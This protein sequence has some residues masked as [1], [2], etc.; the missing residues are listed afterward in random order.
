MIL[1]GLFPDTERVALLWL[2]QQFAKADGVTVYR[3]LPE[4]SWVAPVILIER[5]PGAN[6]AAEYE[7]QTD[8]DVTVFA[9]NRAALWA[10]VQKTEI[11]MR[12]LTGSAVARIDEVEQT[13]SFGL[14]PYS[15]PKVRRAIGGYRTTARPD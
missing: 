6:L 1:R 13:G 14:V 11:A 8:L 9:P 12:A 10:L 7:A 4:T 5:T 2:E 15:N 3:E